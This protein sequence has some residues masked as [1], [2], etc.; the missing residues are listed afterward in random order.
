MEYYKTNGDLFLRLEPGEKLV[1]TLVEVASKEKIEFA[2]IVS[3][4]GMIEGLEMA[5]FCVNDNN[6][7]T[8]RVAGTYD[9]SSIAGNISPFNGAPRT[10]V[11]IVANRPDFSTV[12]G[13]LIEAKA[14]IT[15]EVGLRIMDNTGFRR[16]S[17]PGRPATFITRK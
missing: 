1:E 2:T 10:H 12:S 17:Q 9:L 5:W 11:H 7:D 6:Y 15:M 13:H 14:H 4:V 8:Y 3:G 16:M